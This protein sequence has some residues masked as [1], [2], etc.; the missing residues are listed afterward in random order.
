MNH[1]VSPLTF[2]NIDYIIYTIHQ[3]P[4]LLCMITKLQA[5]CFASFGILWVPGLSAAEMK[6][7]EHRDYGTICDEEA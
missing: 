6:E 1:T 2:C 7:Q 4:L 3:I 5:N